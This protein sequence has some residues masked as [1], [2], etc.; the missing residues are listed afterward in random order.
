MEREIETG[1]RTEREDGEAKGG[2]GEEE[3]T[4]ASYQVSTDVVVLH[5]ENSS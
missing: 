4:S 3:E 1:E 2:R 5:S